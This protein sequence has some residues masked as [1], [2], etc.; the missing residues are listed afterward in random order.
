MRQ[1]QEVKCVPLGS[2][3][4]ANERDRLTALAREETWFVH[5]AIA[6]Q[7]KMQ[8]KPHSHSV[9]CNI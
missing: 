6:A 4:Q 1:Y 2:H 5:L 3:Q 7:A 8:E 9:N